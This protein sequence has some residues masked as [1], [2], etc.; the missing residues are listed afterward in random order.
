MAAQQVG[1]FSGGSI[2]SQAREIE[3]YLA[4]H[5]KNMKT[6]HNLQFNRSA[7]FYLKFTFFNPTKLR[8]DI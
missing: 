8:K 1:V 4:Q 7:Y 3:Y 6:Q 5:L 2:R